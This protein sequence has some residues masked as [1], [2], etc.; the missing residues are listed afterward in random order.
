MNSVWLGFIIV[1]RG[2]I[3]MLFGLFNSKKDNDKSSNM[4]YYA[5]D[6]ATN[7]ND[8]DREYMKP[9]YIVKYYSKLNN[10]VIN[11]AFFSRNIESGGIT[12]EQAFLTLEG[13]LKQSIENRLLINT[14]INEKYMLSN[15]E[16][17]IINKLEDIIKFW[18]PLSIERG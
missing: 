7:F 9:I 17:M 6:I 12:L 10:T 16:E 15:E 11:E 3:I 13:I 14:T 18:L 5:V 1:S 4:K 2:G 8:E